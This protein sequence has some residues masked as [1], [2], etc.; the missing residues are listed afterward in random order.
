MKNLILIAI[1]LICCFSCKKENY[2]E[3]NYVNPCQPIQQTLSPETVLNNIYNDSTFLNNENYIPDTSVYNPRFSVYPRCKRIV[4]VSGGILTIPINLGSLWSSQTELKG[5]YLKIEGSNNIIRIPLWYGPN[6]N[7]F[8]SYNITNND[9]IGFN[10][11]LKD[12]MPAGT[13]NYELV[14]YFTNSPVTTKITQGTVEILPKGGG[15]FSNTTFDVLEFKKNK[16]ETLSLYGFTGGYSNNDCNF[17]DLS[18]NSKFVSWKFNFNNDGTF[19]D[20]RIY[21]VYP[22]YYYDG[23][24]FSINTSDPCYWD[25]YH[26]TNTRKFTV[27]SGKWAYDSKENGLYLSYERTSNPYN[28]SGCDS[29]STIRYDLN[30][31]YSTYLSVTANGTNTYK[32]Q[33]FYPRGNSQLDT[34]SYV[35]KK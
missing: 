20:K 29:D 25:W 26:I 17:N 19:T 27:Y 16:T 7:R 32:L 9:K 12:N 33:E 8:N 31:Y 6:Y 2:N 23:T 10:I 15:F 35:I 34:L 28:C 3:E 24:P 5:I 14:C 13:F 22:T 11:L 4:A 18:W 21:T 30:R 1:V